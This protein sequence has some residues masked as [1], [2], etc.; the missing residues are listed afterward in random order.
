MS[1]ERASEYLSDDPEES[2]LKRR[3]AAVALSLAPEERQEVTSIFTAYGLEDIPAS[4]RPVPQ[5]ADTDST[6]IRLGISAMVTIIS[7][8][9]WVAI[10]PEEPASRAAAT[11]PADVIAAPMELVAR[12]AE[13]A[14]ARELPLPGLASPAQ[15]PSVGAGVSAPTHSRPTAIGPKR[16]RAAV[17][18][19]TGPVPAMSPPGPRRLSGDP[20]GEPKSAVSSP[21]A[22]QRVS[23]TVQDNPY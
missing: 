13:I 5:G 18:V 22:S 4:Q 21:R 20:Y 16:A 23:G 15:T 7:A 12:P 1:T 2:G 14:P 6:L 19:P 10:M 3:T 17:A 8:A 9:V 11:P